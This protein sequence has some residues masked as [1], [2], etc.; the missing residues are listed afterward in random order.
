MA[1]HEIK[2]GKEEPETLYC[3]RLLGETYGENGQTEKS[4][5]LLEDLA[6]R[7]KAKLGQK[8]TDTLDVKRALAES[9]LNAGDLVESI[10]LYEGVV[11]TAESNLGVQHGLTRWTAYGLGE[12]YLSVDEFEK[13]ENLLQKFTPREG[14]DT[15]TLKGT[16][17][18][19]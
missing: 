10:E 6:Q 9:Y 14:E 7:S 4:I 11:S 2:I 16:K 18:V 3:L 5:P 13:A 17:R 15:P 1:I 12:A 8:H 19:Q